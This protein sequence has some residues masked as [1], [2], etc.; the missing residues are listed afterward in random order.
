MKY[1]VKGERILTTENWEE[2]NTTYRKDFD[3]DGNEILIAKTISIEDYAKENGFKIVN[4]KPKELVSK[5]LKVDLENELQQIKKWF[6]ENDYKVNKVFIGEWQQDDA[7]WVEYKQQRALYR[8]R[9][10]E[11]EKEL[12]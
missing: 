10:D 9:L 2:R 12:L 11:I 6:L 4:T 5:E 8:K 7:R 1:L 3:K